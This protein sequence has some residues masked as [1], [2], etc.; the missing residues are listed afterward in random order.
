MKIKI[1]TVGKTK[2]KYWQIAEAIYSKRIQ[3]YVELEQVFVKEAPLDALKNL[4]LVKQ[5]E[6]NKIQ[7][8]IEKDE[9]VIALNKSGIQMASEKFAEFFQKKLLI[10]INKITFVVGGPLG[11]SN[12]LLNHSDLI[13]SLSKMTFPHEMSK[14]I[15]LE[16]IY[17]AFSILQ[18]E[19]YHK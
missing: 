5:T 9:Y 12:E 7:A 2:E 13:L 10:S 4:N 14:V 8:K 3:R 11:L 18:G 6:A 19:K 15:L 17:R 1:I 16:Q